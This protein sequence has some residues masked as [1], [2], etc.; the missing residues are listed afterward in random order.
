MCA[1]GHKSP[2]APTL[3]ISGTIG[4]MPL[5]SICASSCKVLRR[6][7]ELPVASALMRSSIMA[8]TTGVGSGSPTPQAWLM[9]RRSCRISASSGR[10]TVSRFAPNPVVTP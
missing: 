7:P 4:W 6:M 8:R 10:I 9:S 2:L 1:S 3:P 5:L